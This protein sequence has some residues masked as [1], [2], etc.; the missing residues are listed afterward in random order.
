M[1]TLI[2]WLLNQRAL[3]FFQK[4]FQGDTKEAVKELL[5]MELKNDKRLNAYYYDAETIIVQKIIPSKKLQ[6]ENELK[7]DDSA[8]LLA[9]HAHRL[10]AKQTNVAL[11]LRDELSNKEIAEKLCISEET[12][13]SHLKK[14]FNKLD[15]RSRHFIV[16]K[17]EDKARSM[18]PDK[19]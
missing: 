11:H 15:V 5:D 10:S 8:F 13:K 2:L 14:L 4:Y 12:V 6:L 19:S 3:I 16:K 7:P 1:F 9:C 17:L 18:M